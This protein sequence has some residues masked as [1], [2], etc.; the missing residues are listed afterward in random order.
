MEN[1]TARI[2]KI[3]TT[4]KLPDRFIKATVHYPRNPNE[5]EHGTLIFLVEIL[6]PWFPSTEIGN[7]IIETTIA[8]YYSGS[9]YADSL[10]R[11]EEA[12]KKVNE[13]LAEVAAKGVNNW[14]GNLNCTILALKRNNLYVSHSGNTQVYLFREKNLSEVT[15]DISDKSASP[16]STFITITSGS[17]LKRDRILLANQQ[18]LNSIPLQS[19]REIINYTDVIKSTQQ[20]GKILRRKNIR[21]VNAFL[22]ELTTEKEL[23]QLPQEQYLEEDTVYLDQEPETWLGS[24]LKGAKPKIASEIEGGRKSGTR[25]WEKFLIQAYDR[26]Q[27]TAP[28]LQKFTTDIGYVFLKSWHRLRGKN[29]Q[30]MSSEKIQ[31]RQEFFMEKKD[32]IRRE[33]PGI[34]N[35]LSRSFKN[36]FTGSREKTRSIFLAN[37]RKKL[38]ITLAILFILIFGFS[39]FFTLR[40]NWKNNEDVKIEQVIQESKDSLEE[41]ESLIGGN[42]FS[43]ARKILLASFQDLEKYSTNP[44]Y[45]KEIENLKLKLIAYLDKT[46]QTIRFSSTKNLDLMVKNLPTKKFLFLNDVFYYVDNKN[47]LNAASKAGEISK[48]IGLPEQIDKVTTFTNLEDDKII[49]Y[50]N[51]L[52]V[53]SFNLETEK[54]VRLDAVGGWA[55]TDKF[56]TYDTNVYLLNPDNGQIL[57]YIR[58]ALGYSKA[59]YLILENQLP[60]IQEALDFTLDGNVY[61]LAKTE[62]NLVYKFYNGRVEEDF[63]F[64]P[65]PSGLT[66]KEASKIFTKEDLNSLYILEKEVTD[67]DGN[68]INRLLEFSKDGTFVKQYKFSTTLGKIQD[69]YINQKSHKIY[70]LFDSQKLYALDQK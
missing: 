36:I 7:T 34:F 31:K 52:K 35:R 41:S 38:Y 70:L 28:H 1:Y 12:L 66:L 59:R 20:I 13:K 64:N 46:D 18:L 24:I 48:I 29:A 56:K 62:K 30:R 11:F 54:F 22:L 63:S 57:K 8:E 19:L 5:E 43:E 21:N 33:K 67:F 32:T 42:N 47:F 69:F 65:E 10:T 44:K 27:K 26:M 40:K 37:N 3:L 51:D 6:S 45:Q 17:L 60:E 4:Q 49:F 50:T 55:K 68:K 16:I 15:E 39:L 25:M 9:K 2:G 53:Y 58:V 14:L 23:A 61:L